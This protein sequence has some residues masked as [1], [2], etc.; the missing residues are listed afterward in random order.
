[1]TATETKRTPLARLIDLLVEL[2]SR[3][4]A[5]AGKLD[6]HGAGLSV[7][8]WWVG[9][10]GPAIIQKTR[11][12]GYDVYVPLSDSI[13]IDDTERAVREY[14]A[15][16]HGTPTVNR[17][18]TASLMARAVAESQPAA[19][20]GA[21]VALDAINAAGRSESQPDPKAGVLERAAFEADLATAHKLR[22]IAWELLLS[23]RA[24]QHQLGSWLDRWLDRF[25][26]PPQE[27]AT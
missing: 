25:M 13:T 4:L 10:G 1:M 9:T 8:L 14:A 19:S 2:N 15:G 16:Y 11:D 18:L 6:E 23:D 7:E 12:G 3:G 27:A 20:E 22:E 26:K 24:Q 17:Q 5:E 21:G